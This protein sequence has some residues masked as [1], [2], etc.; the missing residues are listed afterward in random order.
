MLERI[1][2]RIFHTIFLDF[3]QEILDNSRNLVFS[4]GLSNLYF[5]NYR[6][7]FFWQRGEHFAGVKRS[8][9]RTRYGVADSGGRDALGVGGD[10]RAAGAG[11][12]AGAGRHSDALGAGGNPSCFVDTDLRI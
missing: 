1:L 10:R 9:A 2:R 7:F 4:A 8:G 12:G 6:E 11:A 5:A 3:F